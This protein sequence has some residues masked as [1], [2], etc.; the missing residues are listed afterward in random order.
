V[1]VKSGIIYFATSKDIRLNSKTDFEEK[2]PKMKELHLLSLQTFAQ[3]AIAQ[4]NGGK[5]VKKNK[6]KR[7]DCSDC[8]GI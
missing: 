4:E 6:I 1:A 7:K 8:M 5:R 2:H 3:F